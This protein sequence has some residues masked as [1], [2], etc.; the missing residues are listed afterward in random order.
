MAANGRDLF[1]GTIPLYTWQDW[2]KPRKKQ[3]GY[4]EH[5]NT[6]REGE[7]EDCCLRTH[8]MFS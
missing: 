4:P 3:T 2:Q 1:R 7:A 5:P 8:E 6:N